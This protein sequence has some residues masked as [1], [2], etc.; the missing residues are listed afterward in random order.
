M[1]GSTHRFHGHSGLRYVYQHG[2]TVRSPQLLLRYV[3]NDRQPG[4][5]AAVVVSRKV[6]KSAVK[7]NRIRRCIYAAV[8]AREVQLGR[9]YDLVFTVLHEELG[10]TPANELHKLVYAQLQK[11]GVLDE[12][13]PPHAIV[14]KAEKED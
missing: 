3:R 1:I 4:Y 10:D 13:P 6:H 11:A 2:Q 12:A 8:Q 5:R 7:R 14:K 9:P